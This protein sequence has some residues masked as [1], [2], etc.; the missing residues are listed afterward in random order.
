MKPT[1]VIENLSA[2]Q[3][4]GQTYLA[5]LLRYLPADVIERYRIVAIAPEI[6]LQKTFV[7]SPIEILSRLS[8]TVS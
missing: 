2:R 7:T 5:N 4:G 3:G 1:I 8:L 6:A